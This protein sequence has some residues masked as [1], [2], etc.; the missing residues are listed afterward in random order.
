MAYVVIFVCL[1]GISIGLYFLLRKD[2]K[3]PDPPKGC[4]IPNYTQQDFDRIMNPGNNLTYMP[5]DQ[6]YI[7]PGGNPSDFKDIQ[8]CNKCIYGADFDPSDPSLGMDPAFYYNNTC[9]HSQQLGTLPDEN[10]TIAAQGIENQMCIPCNKPGLTSYTRPSQP[11]NF[12]KTSCEPPSQPDNPDKPEPGG[13]SQPV[14]PPY[15]PPA[16]PGGPS[17]SLSID[18][19]TLSNLAPVLIDQLN[20]NKPVNPDHVKMILSALAQTKNFKNACSDYYSQL[21][22]KIKSL[23][24]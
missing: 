4:D 19:I 22:D 15:T 12:P 17:P 3:T 11:Y 2:K 9:Y 18:V 7:I 6:L 5:G 24:K 16:E 21:S 1:I 20:Q 14:K 8:D 10:I 13:P 23:S